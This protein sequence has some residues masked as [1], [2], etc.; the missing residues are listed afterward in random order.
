[1]VKKRDKLEVIYDILSIIRKNNNC[2][3]PIPLLRISNLSSQRF[4][5]Y[6]KEL[7]EGN[8]I[9]E[10]T[11]K[12]ERKSY[13]LTDKGFNYLEKYKIIQGFIEDFDL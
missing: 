10:I 2:I 8:F 4:N 7:E 6:I 9:K 13:T 3:K 1:M 5:E 11:D 12:K